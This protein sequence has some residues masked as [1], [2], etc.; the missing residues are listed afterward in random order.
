M[1]KWKKATS[2]VYLYRC[3]LYRMAKCILATYALHKISS[4]S[5]IWINVRNVSCCFKNDHRLA[6]GET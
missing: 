1:I 4:R 3:Q 2:E 6:N 5:Y